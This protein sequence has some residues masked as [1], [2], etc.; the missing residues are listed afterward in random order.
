MFTNKNRSTNMA[1]ASYFGLR[2][3]VLWKMENYSLIRCGGRELV[4]D[5]SDLVFQ[6]T[7]S[8]TA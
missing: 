1:V 8:N 3:V 6:Q 7:A 2:V 4:V 5:I